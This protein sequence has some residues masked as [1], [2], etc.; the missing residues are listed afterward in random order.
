MLS[1]GTLGRSDSIFAGSPGWLRGRNIVITAGTA[2]T[3]NAWYLAN[4]G[5]SVAGKSLTE[6]VQWAAAN[7]ELPAEVCGAS[8]SAS[9]LQRE[10]FGKDPG[11]GDPWGA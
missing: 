1:Q 3:F 2:P 4:E 6:W 5:I 7:D 8:A 9:T 11:A 10:V